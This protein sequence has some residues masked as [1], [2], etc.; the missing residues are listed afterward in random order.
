MESVKSFNNGTPSG[1]SGNAVRPSSG[2]STSNSTRTSPSGNTN[3]DVKQV[4]RSSAIYKQAYDILSKDEDKI[5]LQRLETIVNSVV[6]YT[7]NAFREIFN[8]DDIV[9]KNREAISLAYQQIQQLLAEYQE[10]RNSLPSTQ[11]QQFSDANLNPLTQSFSGSNIN[12]S[13]TPQV[14]GA[15]QLTPVTDIISTLSSVALNTTSG[16]ISFISTFRDLAFKE[17]DNLL[18]MTERGIIVPKKSVSKSNKSFYESLLNSPFA[19]SQ[20]NK[21]S[22]EQLK[23]SQDFEFSEELYNKLFPYI[24]D[25]DDNSR[26]VSEIFK[27]LANLNFEIFKGDMELRNSSQQASKSES[28]FNKKLFDNLDANV[29]AEATNSTNETTVEKNSYNNQYIRNQ[30][31][32]E[33]KFSN[34]L[35]KWIQ[36]ANEGSLAHMY[37]LLNLRTQGNTGVGNLL[38]TVKGI[39]K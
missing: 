7:G 19:K 16:V 11:A 25:S 9:N 10:F 13:I 2:V 21:W 36:R 38:D 20:H 30:K 31:R 39:V 35:D 6:T 5:W 34:L 29:Q 17:R 8:S 23:T 24:E 33:R 12:P 26:G 4:I 32:I 14:A 22:S 15:P 28:D 18:S 3:Y 37:F 27:D 1:R